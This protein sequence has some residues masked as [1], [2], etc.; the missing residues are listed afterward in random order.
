MTQ[1]TTTPNQPVSTE[2]NPPP[3][4]VSLTERRDQYP[5]IIS[6]PLLDS[7]ELRSL[8]DGSQ[9]EARDKVREI[10]GSPELT[11]QSFTNTEEERSTVLKWCQVLADKGVG[12]K[13]F[14]TEYGGTQDLAGFFASF[15]MLAYH[16]L[17]LTI[18]FGVQYGL[19]GGSVLN[20]GTAPHHKEILA[21]CNS[22]KLPGCFAMTEIGHGSNVRQIETT[23]TYDHQTKT[24]TIHSPSW[25]AGKIYIGN[26]A[27]DGEMAS[28]FA[29]LYIGGELK[30]VHAFLVPIRDPQKK[31]LPGIHIDD[32]GE[33]IGLNG[34][35]NGLIWFNQVKV[36]KGALLNR[37]A[38]VDENGHWSSEIESDSKRFFTMLGTLV[39]GRMSIAGTAV[40]A[41]QKGLAI[42]TIYAHRR[43]QFGPEGAPET[44]LIDY[45]THQ[46]RLGAGIATTTALSFAIQDLTEL[47]ALNKG[48]TTRKV[49]ARAAA[50][51]AYATWESMSIL[52]DC[53]EAC[54]GEG[55]LWK[56]QIGELKADLDVFTTFE[57]D[58]TVLMQLAAKSLFAQLKQRFKSGELSVSKVVI[59]NLRKKFRK[60]SAPSQRT[61]WHDL[62]V[63]GDLLLAKENGMTL[64]LAQ[65][66]RKKRKQGISTDELMKEYQLDL[67]SLGSVYAERL[68][69]Q[70]ITG[71]YLSLSRENPQSKLIKTLALSFGLERILR[72]TSW[73]FKNHYLN[74]EC[75]G[76]AVSTL[77]NTYPEIAKSSLDIIEAYGIPESNITA[78][79]AKA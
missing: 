33:K 22:L 9:A 23:A 37:F 71:K 1:I 32:N 75:H 35:D 40:K 57:G 51:K 63:I 78:P 46:R 49:E 68:T 25:S 6:V 29:Q 27:R 24:F 18:K 39:G 53:R 48:Q 70:S 74:P 10:L 41:T 14:P 36:P 52:Q 34:V 19:F 11:P 5:P 59:N 20:L 42:A 30:G 67:V 13:L 65:I 31:L 69:F 45:P 77:R 64:D 62:T 66:M 26:S 47:H 28:V 17:S 72:D 60:M 56:N 38:N 76:F 79:I 21:D 12:A 50:L 15:E 4:R 8:F 3:L 73:F 43:R 54:G 61:N 55:Y 7:A 44:L 16:N 58:N 2:Q